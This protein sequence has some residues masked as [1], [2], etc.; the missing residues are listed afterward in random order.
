VGIN[1]R[2]NAN[3]KIKDKENDFEEYYEESKEK[4]FMDDPSFKKFHK[5]LLQKIKEAGYHPT[6]FFTEVILCPTEDG[7]RGLGKKAEDRI[8]NTCTSNYLKE[9]IKIEMPKV[10]VAGGNL[11]VT[12]IREQ[13]GLPYKKVQVTKNVGEKEKIRVDH[14]NLWLIWS[15]H[16]NAQIPKKVISKKEVIEKIYGEIVS[17]LKVS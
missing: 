4:S 16:Q 14:N 13:F 6:S 7:V 2:K 12:T 8:A 17:I 1:P 10:I 15:P 9:L 3:V 11:P 5:P